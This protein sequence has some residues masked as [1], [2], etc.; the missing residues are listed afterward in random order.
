M[1]SVRS[2]HQ[3]FR[4]RSESI[5]GGGEGFGSSFGDL[6]FLLDVPLVI[7]LFTQELTHYH[8]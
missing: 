7:Y 1:T 8:L 4:K 3:L 5:V 2:D 6:S